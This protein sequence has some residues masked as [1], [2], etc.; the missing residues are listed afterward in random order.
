MDEIE[1]YNFK[2]RADFLR[3]IEKNKNDLIGKRI[4]GFFND[5][6]YESGS[7]SPVVLMFDNY[8]IMLDYMFLSDIKIAVF[9]VELFEQ[10]PTLLFV[11]KKENP[12]VRLTLY[13]EA[14]DPDFPFYDCMIEDISLDGFSHEFEV[15]AATGITRPA[16]GDYFSVI[17]VQM[18][19]GRTMCICAASSICCGY[20]DTWTE[21]TL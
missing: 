18:D 2:Y 1:I 3:F 7:C 17:R 19:N 5:I 12:D 21:W 15:S 9:P 16:G 14:F 11:Y 20:L 6:C 8:C 10:D 4:R 13:V